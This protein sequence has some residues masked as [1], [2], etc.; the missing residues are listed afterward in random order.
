MRKEYMLFLSVCLGF[1]VTSCTATPGKETNADY[2]DKNYLEGS[3]SDIQ[4]NVQQLEKRRDTDQKKY[5]VIDYQE[6][7]PK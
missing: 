3:Q 1:F 7:K 4:K 5:D 6:N 2:Q